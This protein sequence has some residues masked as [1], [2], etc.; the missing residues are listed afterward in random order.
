VAQGLI[1]R[2]KNDDCGPERDIPRTWDNILDT[3][4]ALNS[5]DLLPDLSLIDD[6][7]K[8]QAV[9]DS[10]KDGRDDDSAVMK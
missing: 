3:L 10:I 4:A 8:R 1:N 7:S 6:V 5:Q 2:F 9:T